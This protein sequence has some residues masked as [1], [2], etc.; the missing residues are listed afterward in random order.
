MGYAISD[1]WDVSVGYRTIE[2]GADVE[3]AYNFAWLHLA[4]LSV[5]FRY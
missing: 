3:Q 5:R 1:H 4:V 2:G